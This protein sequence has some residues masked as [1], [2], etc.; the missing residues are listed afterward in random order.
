M[1]D[2]PLDAKIISNALDF[3]V[4]KENKIDLDL[5]IKVEGKAFASLSLFP[6][7]NHY[8]FEI[9]KNGREVSEGNAKKVVGGYL[10]VRKEQINEI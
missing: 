6:E 3:D 9:H 1:A 5:G 10:I 7:I 2:L 4:R 8:D